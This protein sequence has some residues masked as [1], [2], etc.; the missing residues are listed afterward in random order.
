MTRRTDIW[1]EISQGIWTAL[2]S[3]FISC[4]GVKAADAPISI[5]LSTQSPLESPSGQV[6][7]HFKQRVEAKSNGAILVDISF[8]GKLYRERE[9]AGA[10][11]SGAVEIGFAS[12]ARYVGIS[13]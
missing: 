13:H 2:F 7:L 9:I 4:S 12:M 5:R 6:M 8:S 10:V 1:I 3:F 11:S